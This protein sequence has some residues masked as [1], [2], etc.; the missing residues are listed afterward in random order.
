MNVILAETDQ[1]LRQPVNDDDFTH[2]EATRLANQ[3]RL[4]V[5]PVL[6]DGQCVN[7]V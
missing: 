7:E 6:T 2:R 1:S 3:Q 4:K 5:G